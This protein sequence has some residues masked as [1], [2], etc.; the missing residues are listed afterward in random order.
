MVTYVRRMYV[1]M[2]GTYISKNREI[3]PA[4]QDVFT[5]INLPVE[6][7]GFTR[8]Y[9]ITAIQHLC[10]TTLHDDAHLLH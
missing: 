2:D 7:Y 9:V 1:N 4:G 5:S 8:L 10:K 6:M 3:I